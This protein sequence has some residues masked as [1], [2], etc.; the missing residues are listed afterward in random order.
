MALQGA[1]RPGAG[2]EALRLARFEFQANAAKTYI[3]S[4]L[5]AFLQLGTLKVPGPSTEDSQVTTGGPSPGCR[6]GA[7]LELWN[8]TLKK[9]V[10]L[11][12][13]RKA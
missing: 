1:E 5:Q 10:V 4:Y 9:Q 6:L 12:E 7:F 8:L 2:L 3:G 11:V 13:V